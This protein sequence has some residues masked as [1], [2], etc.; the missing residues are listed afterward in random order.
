MQLPT[1]SIRDEHA[2]RVI[3]AF[4]D[5]TAYKAWLREQVVSYVVGVEQRA[6]QAEALEQQRAAAAALRTE[7]SQEA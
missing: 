4:G 5:V 6:M 2:D 3:A 1:I 7:L